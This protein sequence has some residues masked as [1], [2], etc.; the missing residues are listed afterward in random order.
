M[1]VVI[2]ACAIFALAAALPQ[3][4]HTQHHVQQHVQQ[5]HVQQQGQ[6]HEQP[7]RPVSR[8]Q[9]GQYVH[10]YNAPVHQHHDVEASRQAK[11]VHFDSNL[12]LGVEGYN[13]RLE[14]TDGIK[15]QETG[16][17]E[18]VGTD[19][20]SLVVVGEYSYPGGPNG[21]ILTVKYVADR[22]GFQPQGEHLH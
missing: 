5:Q 22:N 17:F 11:L 1:K 2:F 3:P 19:D 6:Y 15:K 10:H 7:Q 20:E 4:Q 18:N 21:E 12:G 9:D 13:Y 8:Q 16:S 14:S